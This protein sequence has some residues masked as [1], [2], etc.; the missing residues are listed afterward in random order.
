LRRARQATAGETAPPARFFAA[1]LLL[2]VLSSALPAQSVFNP[3]G[4]MACCRGTKSMS[5]TGD[6]NSCPLCRRAK[7]EPRKTGNS[8]RREVMCGADLA[9][10]KQG[11]AALSTHALLLKAGSDARVRAEVEDDRGD[12]VSP[13]DAAQSTSR[14]ASAG[15]AS[16]ARPCP[17]DCCGTA[18]GSLNGSR[19]TRHEAA[20]NE[21]IRP[22]PPTAEPHTYAPSGLIKDTT[23]LRRGCP[24]RAPPASPANRT[25]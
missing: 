7:A 10:R 11:G 19:R 13:R 12:G 23:L 14:Q 24:P 5:G 4:L 18:A 17:S 20:L 6:G 15:G 25:A 9:L 16:L 21:G 2:C 22:R 1:A 8:V 3:T